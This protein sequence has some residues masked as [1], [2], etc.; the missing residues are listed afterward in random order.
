MTCT[1]PGSPQNK[2]EQRKIKIE[3]R[4]QKNRTS[5]NQI[6]HRIDI[7]STSNREPSSVENEKSSG[8]S[9]FVYVSVSVNEFVYV[10]EFEKEAQ[11][12]ARRF[13]RLFLLQMQINSDTQYQKQPRAKY[14]RKQTLYVRREAANGN[15]C[16]CT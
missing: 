15:K 4:K 1:K 12:C 9:E 11:K 8:V 7:E 3:Y 10:Y 16:L 5:K 2:I 14:H 6:R 13:T